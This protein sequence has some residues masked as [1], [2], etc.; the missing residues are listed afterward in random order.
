[1]EEKDIITKK[2]KGF[3]SLVS[4]LGTIYNKV[5]A[6]SEQA[7]DKDQELAE[8]VKAAYEEW[9][10][11]ENFFHSVTDPDLVDHAIYKLEATKSRYI[12]LLKQA[13]AS[14]IRMNL[15]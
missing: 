12:Y 11:A 3:S 4:A 14:G 6:T 10:G 7:V 1:M 9:Q 15:H 5:N 8:C 13:K 2:E